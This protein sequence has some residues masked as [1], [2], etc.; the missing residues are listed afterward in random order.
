MKILSDMVILDVISKVGITDTVAAGIKQKLFFP[1][2]NMPINVKVTVNGELNDDEAN[3]LLSFKD[4]S[5]KVIDSKTIELSKATY[6][7]KSVVIEYFLKSTNYISSVVAHII[8]FNNTEI[9]TNVTLTLQV[10]DQSFEEQSAILLNT[11]PMHATFT[12]DA[13]SVVSGDP[14]TL[15]VQLQKI[16]EADLDSMNEVTVYVMDLN[17]GTPT[18]ATV[19][20]INVTNGILLEEIVVRGTLCVVSNNVGLITFELTNDVSGDYGVMI[21]NANGKAFMSSTLSW[22]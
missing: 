1:D 6:D 21:V 3:I 5:G 10:L 2:A 16:T 22:T 18:P 7:N 12:A 9:A 13:E 4:D 17:G 14:I 8:K 11:I 19:T 20:T 15:D